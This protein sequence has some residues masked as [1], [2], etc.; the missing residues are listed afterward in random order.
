L[1]ILYRAGCLAEQEGTPQIFP[2]H[3]RQAKA[4]FYPELK[5]HVLQE[6]RP[7]EI[8]TLLAVAR[9]LRSTKAAYTTAKES[10]ETYQVACEEYGVEPLA[11]TRFWDNL[12]R[13]RT[14]GFLSMKQLRA[15]GV[16]TLLSIEEAPLEVLIQELEHLSETFKKT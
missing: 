3:A 15:K 7:Q 14:L 16:T 8:L 11:Y 10:Y 5:K 9:R 6:L 12:E 2:E 1:E 4:S 13:L